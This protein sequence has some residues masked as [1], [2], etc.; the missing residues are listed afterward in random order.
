MRT[1]VAFIFLI[2]LNGFATGSS[3]A[4]MPDI[5]S[6][7][8]TSAKEHHDGVPQGGL[9]WFF[10]IWIDFVDPGDLHHTDVTK[11]G[12][13]EPFTTIDGDGDFDSPSGYSSLANLRTDY[14]LGTYVFEFRDAS[15]A[16]LT[17]VNLD[18]SDMPGEPANPVNFTYP[19]ADGQTGVSTTPTLTWT[20]DNGHALM[21]GL[22]DI[23]TDQDVSWVAP[24]SI[25]TT[26]WVPPGPLQ[27]AHEYNLEVS[28]VQVKDWVGPDW[29][30]MT[31]GTDQFRYSLMIEYINSI[32]FTTGEP[33]A[34]L[35]DWNGDGIRSIIGDVPGFVNA[36]YFNQYPNGWSLEQRLAAG[37]GNGDG[38][39]SIIGDVPPFVNCVY[40]GQCD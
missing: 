12:G 1:N 3:G 18:Y 16:L 22:E 27:S 2:V 13:L 20:V 19:S 39:L 24:A 11:P 38:I 5:D 37:D 17:T 28:V 34:L 29:P 26:S 23:T 10:E 30:T 15:N 6:I 9:P 32:D 40:F 8:I 25:G 7:I 35:H 21:M 36:V 14:P 31:V 33:S 4:G